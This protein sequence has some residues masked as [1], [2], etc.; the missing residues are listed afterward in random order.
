ML[1]VLGDREICVVREISKKFEEVTF[2]TLS[3]GFEGTVKGEFV[4]LIK[5]SNE[6][7][8]I[9]IDKNLQ[10]L[11]DMGLSKTDASK[12]IAKLTGVK[13]SDVYKNAIK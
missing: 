1:E 3:R 8:E 9:N 4:V 12:V 11:L 13:K 10:T 6:K 7:M 5:Y 2:S